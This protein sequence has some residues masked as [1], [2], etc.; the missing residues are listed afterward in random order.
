MGEYFKLMSRRYP[1]QGRARDTRGNVEPNTAISIYLAETTTPATVY[2]D[3]TGG[4]PISTVPQIYS[5]SRGY[6][7]C[8]LEIEDFS[9]SDR[10][11]VV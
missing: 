4:D 9:S 3:Y 7:E 2:T 1:F 11:S 5:D 6:F 10:K 8:H